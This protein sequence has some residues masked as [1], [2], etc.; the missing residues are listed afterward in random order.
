[1]SKY[2]KIRLTGIRNEPI[3]LNEDQ[4][5]SGSTTIGVLKNKICDKTGTHRDSMRLLF[6]ST[7]LTESIHD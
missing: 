6:S 4:M 2:F 7:E 3:I 1:M 5:I